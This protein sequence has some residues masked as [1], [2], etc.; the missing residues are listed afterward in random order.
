LQHCWDQL[1][2]KSDHFVFKHE[3]SNKD[4]PY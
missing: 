1:K 4:S 2:C 3:S